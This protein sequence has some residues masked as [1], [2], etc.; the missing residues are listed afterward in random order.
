MLIA[1]LDNIRNP[2]LSRGLLNNLGETRMQ[3]LLMFFEAVS[4]VVLA[5]PLLFFG[6]IGLLGNLTVTFFCWGVA[7]WG[8]VELL[9]ML[10]Q[11]GKGEA[12]WCRAFAAQLTVSQWQR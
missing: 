8:A 2:M 4:I 11:F 9:R 10:F 5:L 7:A 3:S 6:F 12:G 1:E